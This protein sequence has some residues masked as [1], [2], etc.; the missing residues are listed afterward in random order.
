[1]SALIAI[2]IGFGIFAIQCVLI[3]LAY[4]RL[5]NTEDRTENTLQLL[6]CI[7]FPVAW[8]ITWIVIGRFVA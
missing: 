8:I 2:M 1:M 7:P 5:V 6:F 4:V 3:L